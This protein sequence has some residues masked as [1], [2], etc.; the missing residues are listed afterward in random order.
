MSLW[1]HLNAA[2]LAPEWAWEIPLFQ[3]LR[4]SGKSH[5]GDASRPCSM[6]SSCHCYPSHNSAACLTHTI[7]SLSL[8]L[9]Y[10]LLA[11][12]AFHFSSQITPHPRSIKTQMRKPW[13]QASTSW[14]RKIKS[15]NASLTNLAGWKS[16]P[17]SSL[18]DLKT[19]CGKKVGSCNISWRK[20]V[21]ETS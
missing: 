8:W 16:P 2:R 4:D 6:D 10:S 1:S 13:H 21:P 17:S 19:M 18:Q 5:R 3:E 7:P 14:V 11:L 9:S 20:F 12:M 15:L